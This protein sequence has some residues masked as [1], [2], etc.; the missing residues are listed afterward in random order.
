MCN[1]FGFFDN[2]LS[3][4]VTLI[5]VNQNFGRDKWKSDYERRSVL[6]VIYALHFVVT[7]SSLI[8]NEI[9]II[10]NFFFIEMV[11]FIKELIILS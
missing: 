10:L 7:H 4:F 5:S 6:S 1:K 11:H 2:V 8:S 3:L 9:N